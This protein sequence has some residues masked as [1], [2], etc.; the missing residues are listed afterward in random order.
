MKKRY[1]LGMLIGWVSLGL[2]LSALAVEE[3]SPVMVDHQDLAKRSIRDQIRSLR[4]ERIEK[5]P[6]LDR[7]FVHGAIN[8]KKVRQTLDFIAGGKKNLQSVIGRAV[9]VHTPALASKE[10][11]KLAERRILVAMRELFPELEIT[12][13]HRD[14]QIGRAHV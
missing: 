10:R 12:Y 5:M 3:V 6:Y 11:V 9:Q 14:G 7:G 13:Q 8:E 1:I 4:Q 2:P